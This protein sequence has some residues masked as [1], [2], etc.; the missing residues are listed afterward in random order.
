MPSATMAD[1]RLSIPA[2]KAMVK[3]EG[4][5]S[6][7]CASVKAGRLGN[8][9]LEGISPK[10]EPM[11]STGRSIAQTASAA[12]T[13][14]TRKAGHVGKCRRASRDTARAAEDTA[15]GDREKVD[16]GRTR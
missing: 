2:R 14:A 15:T 7:A 8:G 12:P 16:L 10:R 11:V 6:M 3:A 13:T 4:S 9:R 5:T 1:S